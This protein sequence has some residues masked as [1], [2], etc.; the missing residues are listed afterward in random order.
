MQQDKRPD[1]QRPEPM[2][3]LINKEINEVISVCNK[4]NLQLASVS[5][6]SKVSR[7]RLHGYCREV[8][9]TKKL[10]CQG[11]E[12]GLVSGY[13]LLFVQSAWALFLLVHDRECGELAAQLLQ[14]SVMRKQW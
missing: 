2:N 1:V 4:S 13:Y 10:S 12:S 9:N 3:K 14:S 6:C 8:F 5:S 7:S 11:T